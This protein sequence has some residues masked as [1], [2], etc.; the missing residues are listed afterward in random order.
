M[1]LFP[2]NLKDNLVGYQEYRDD[3]LN[4]EQNGKCYG[5]TL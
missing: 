5:R 3:E 2:K 4:D 1:P